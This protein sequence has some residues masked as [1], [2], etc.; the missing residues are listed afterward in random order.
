MHFKAAG[1]IVTPALMNKAIENQIA[2]APSQYLWRYDRYKQ[3]R[4][5]QEKFEKQLEASENTQASE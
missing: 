1:N 3:R 2:Q 4:H 5:A